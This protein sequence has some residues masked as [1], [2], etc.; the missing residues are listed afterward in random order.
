MLVVAVGNL[1]GVMRG[2]VAVAERL[3]AVGRAVPGV[4]RPDVEGVMRPLVTGVIRPLVIGVIRPFG[5]E[6]VTRP[7]DTEGVLRMFALE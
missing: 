4:R 5:N 1:T 3:R 6:G 7:F 2:C